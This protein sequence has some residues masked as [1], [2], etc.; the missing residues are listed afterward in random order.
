MKSEKYKIFSLA[1][2]VVASVLFGM[3]IAGALNV[4]PGVDADPPEALAPVPASEPV[5]VT[6]AFETPNFAAL[7]DRVVPA[8]V[9]VFS[10]EVSDPSDRRGM[11]RDPFHN[12]FFGPRTDPDS[13]REPEPMIRQSS[14]SGFFISA[15]GEI[16]TNNHVIEDATKIEI[17]LDDDTRYRVTVVGRDPATDL[18][19]LKVDQPDQEFTH[20]ALGDSETVRVGEWVMAVGNPLQMDHTVTVGVV[21]AKGRTLGLSSVGSSFENFIQTDAAINLGNSGGPLVNLSGQVIGINTAIN[22]AGQN[23]GFAVP[24]NIARRVVPQLRERGRVVRGYLGVTVTNVDQDTARAFGLEDRRGALVQEVE[25]DHAADKGGVRHGDVILE[26]DGKTVED[27]RDL[28]DTISALPPGTDVKL[29]IVRDGRP[30]TLT[31]ELEERIRE[32]EQVE[33][34][35]EPRDE[36]EAATRVGVTVSDLTARLRQYY[37]VEEGI[38]GVVITHVRAVSPAGEEGLR[39]GDVITEANGRSTS[40]SDDLLA[41]IDAVEDGG[42]LRLY[43][44]RPRFDRSFFAILKLDE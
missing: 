40:T 38:D 14:G 6:P 41:A 30:M 28:I 16:L 17:E 24:V 29:D 7:A 1:A 31:V 12:F 19:L 11:P 35:E 2:I 23:L 44:Y 43:V 5:S 3:V 13:D 32:G 36:D 21:S 27:T 10:T 39:E 42:Y 26:V 8:V 22:A 20:L 4:T 15:E 37:G 34:E 9:S 18:A 25:P 33:G